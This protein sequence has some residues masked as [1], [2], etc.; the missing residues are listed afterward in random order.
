MKTIILSLSLIALQT[1]AGFAATT[2]TQVGINT[3]CTDG[4]AGTTTTCTQ[5]GSTVICH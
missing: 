2:C 1:T 4:G 5:V 3:I